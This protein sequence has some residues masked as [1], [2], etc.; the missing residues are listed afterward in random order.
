[1]LLL[2][3]VK[4]PFQTYEVLLK[5]K[6]TWQAWT[7]TV[8][9]FLVTSFIEMQQN[10][11]PN[12]LPLTR[13]GRTLAVMFVA[14]V[15]GVILLLGLTLICQGVAFLLGGKAGWHDIF[16]VISWSYAPGLLTNLGLGFLL[17]L[18]PLPSL[19]LISNLF[20]VVAGLWTIV[21]MVIGLRVAQNFGVWRATITLALTWSGLLMAAAIVAG[22]FRVVS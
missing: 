2:S 16:I 17:W 3:L 4:N 7:A 22:L 6:S 15:I 20:Q 8:G 11:V 14:L 5:E 10:I 1:M 19:S 21:L 9:F 13:P 18:A 12:R